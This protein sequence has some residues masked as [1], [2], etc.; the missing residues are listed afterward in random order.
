MSAPA[1]IPATEERPTYWVETYGCEM[2]DYDSEFI[3]SRFL[4]EGYAPAA[5]AEMADVLLFNTCSVRQGAEDRVRARIEN[6]AGRKRTKPK[7]L[8][9]VVGCM[10][11][12]LGKSLDVGKGLVDLVV[13]TDAYRDL[14]ELVRT[15]LSSPKGERIVATEIESD[16]T[17]GIER[18]ASPP[19]GPCAFLT[20]MQ[21]CDKFCTFCIVPYTR[22]RERSKPSHEV[23]AEAERLVAR[24][25]RQITLLG[26]N[27]NSYRDG[28]VDFAKLLRLVDKV[29]GLERVFFTSSY[30]RDMTENVFHAIAEC[31]TPIAFLHF[32]VQSGSDRVLRRMKR[33]HTVEWY[34]RQIDLARKII[35]DVQFSTDLIVGFPGESHSDFQATLDLIER[36]RF[37]ECFM[38]SFSPRRGTPAER[39]ADELS[40][41]EKASRLQELIDRQRRIGHDVLVR[42]LGRRMEVLVEGPSRRDPREP[43]GRTRNRFMVVLPPHSALP[44][45]LVDV[46]LSQLKGSTFRGNPLNARKSWSS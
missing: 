27:V 31:R 37:A 15:R 29:E 38:Y 42:N 16:T 12:R 10:A 20:I 8:I 30:P 19:P 22:G 18:Y 3:A 25:A 24:G 13:G 40:A 36:V 28:D 33:R 7:G 45:E 34:L 21:G 2:N 11:Q 9:G 46:E 35:P 6:F 26:Q 44:G 5:S 4:E 39:L 32:P 23:V 43:F 14:P 17:Y 1:V 41:D